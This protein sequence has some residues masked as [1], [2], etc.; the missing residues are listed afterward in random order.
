MTSFHFL[1][2]LTIVCFSCAIYVFCSMKAMKYFYSSRSNRSRLTGGE[3]ARRI[4]EHNR[5][6]HVTIQLAPR[7]RTSS[8]DPHQKEVNLAPATYSYATLGAMAIAAH[9]CGHAAQ[10]RITSVGVKLSQGGLGVFM[11][12]LILLFAFPNIWL[13]VI[14]FAGAVVYFIEKLSCEVDASKRGLNSL[15][16]L[17][18]MEPDEVKPVK[19]LLQASFLTYVFGVFVLAILLIPSLASIFNHDSPIF[20]LPWIG[21]VIMMVIPAN[22]PSKSSGR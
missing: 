2:G 6:P 21:V 1:I 4:V 16:Q 17:G 11:I 18:I 12:C 19:K 9:E 3:I 8:Y 5:L 13:F 20:Y 10:N 22:F 7:R 15:R 14:G